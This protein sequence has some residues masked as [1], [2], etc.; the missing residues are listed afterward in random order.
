V[1]QGKGAQALRALKTPE[2]ATPQA[3]KPQPPPKKAG[4]GGGAVLPKL[5]ENPSNV[6][7]K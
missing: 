6:S 1:Q 5:K 7:K 3:L 4:G 2:Q